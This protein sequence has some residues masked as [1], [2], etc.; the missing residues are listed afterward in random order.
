MRIARFL[1]LISIMLLII[2]SSCKKSKTSAGINADTTLI[3]KDSLEKELKEIV[4]PLPSPFEV[5][6]KLEDIG[7]TYMSKVLNP[8]KNIDKYFTDRMK[9]INLG[10]YAA[11]LSYVTTYNKTQEIQ[12]Y[13]KNVKQL[14][15]DLKLNIDYEDLYSEETR[16]KLENKDTLVKYITNTFHNVYKE[17]AKSGDPSL[18]VLMVTG[19]W[20]EGLYIASHISENTFENTEIVKIIY[21]QRKSLEIVLN[22]LSNHLN[23]DFNKSLYNALMKIKNA[24][25]KAKDGLTRELLNEITN[26]I[27]NVRSS[28]VD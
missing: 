16:K 5:Y 19:V 1:S 2:T 4:Y 20:F 18:A 27:E 3:S 24:Y 6:Q 26:S 28:I 23:T 21:D 22:L 14:I 10:I 15:D 25:D 11:D 13:S 17:L 12:L 8:A 9:A 7:A